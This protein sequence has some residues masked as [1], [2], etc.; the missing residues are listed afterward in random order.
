MGVSIPAA[1]SITTS[2]A[3]SFHRHPR[4]C[5]AA[6]RLDHVATIVRLRQV[7]GVDVEAIRLA[8]ENAS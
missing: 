6:V 2:L 3:K 1:H 7:L 5:I 8:L 4:P